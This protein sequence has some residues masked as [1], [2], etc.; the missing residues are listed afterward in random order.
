MS[1][2]EAFTNTFNYLSQK[3]NPLREC[4]RDHTWGG[5][6]YA[7][8]D[9]TSSDMNT[10]FANYGLPRLEWFE[11]GSY[12][13]GM[14]HI[15]DNYYS[16]RVRCFDR[17]GGQPGNLTLH[18]YYSTTRNKYDMNFIGGNGVMGWIFETNVT[19]AKNYTYAF[20]GRDSRHSIW[21]AV[22]LP[23]WRV[24]AQ[25]PHDVAITNIQT[26]TSVAIQ[27]PSVSINV[28]VEN[29]GS[30]EESFNVTAYANTTT[31]QTQEVNLTS[32]SS[33]IITF[34]WNTTTFGRQ[35]YHKC[36]GRCSNK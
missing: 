17:E 31:I 29:Q 9:Q 34:A 5:F 7:L 24:R 27:N 2:D 16:F 6:L 35:L 11:E 36:H 26:S 14:M 13:K 1:T 3:G 15:D 4:Y 33:T 20:S 30:Y 32:G 12:Q 21:Q 18:V 28:T 22:G 23:T 8:G 25:L 19:L 10:I